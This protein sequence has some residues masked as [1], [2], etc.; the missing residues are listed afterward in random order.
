VDWNLKFL[1]NP[2]EATIYEFQEAAV[3]TFM[4]VWEKDSNS[5]D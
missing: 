1:K 5:L 2:S 4:E 3:R